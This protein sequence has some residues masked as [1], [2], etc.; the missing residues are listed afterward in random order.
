MAGLLGAIFLALAGYGAV[1]S[2][3]NNAK[4]SDYS[5]HTAKENN[6]VWYNDGW[7]QA[8][9]TQTNEPVKVLS[10]SECSAVIG[11]SGKV[12]Q[13]QLSPEKLEELR[14]KNAIQYCKEN[15]IKYLPWHFNTNGDN[16]CSMGVEIETGKKYVIDDGGLGNYGRE[17]FEVTYLRDRPST[18]NTIYGKQKFYL[19][20]NDGTE[21]EHRYYFKYY[22]KKGSDKSHP[23]AKAVKVPCGGWYYTRKHIISREDYEERIKEV[24]KFPKY[25]NYN[26][27][28]ELPPMDE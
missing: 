10:N 24:E 1:K 15:G 25:K 21:E 22:H 11:K 19:F 13:A 3:V 5:K 9:S 7:G 23:I 17:T 27:V 16:V 18:L 4:Y 12:Y 28:K 2:E 6:D 26:V 8:R 14:L 20:V